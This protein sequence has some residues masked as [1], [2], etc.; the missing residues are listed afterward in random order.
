MVSRLVGRT[1][2]NDL[3]PGA[4]GLQHLEAAA[5]EIE[6]IHDQIYNLLTLF[7]LDTAE[8]ED[9]D[10]IARVIPP[11]GVDPRQGATRAIGVVT[12]FGATGS[13]VPQGTKVAATSVQFRTTATATIGG[14]GFVHVA[15]QAVEPGTSGNVAAGAVTRIVSQVAGV[16]GVVNAAAFSGG[17]D[18]ETDDHFRNRIRE[19]QRSLC[20]ATPNA[21]EALAKTIGVTAHEDGETGDAVKIFKESTPVVRRVVQAKI[22]EDHVFRGISTLYIDDGN[23]FQGVSSAQLV[24]TLGGGSEDVL[25]SI[26]T[27]GERRLQTSH[28]PIELG[29]AITLEI[30][31]GGAGPWVLLTEGADYTI[32]RSN[33][34]VVLAA[35]LPINTSVRA[36]Y[37]YSLDLVHAVQ[38]AVE[39]DRLD[40]ARW[41]GWR[42]A[43]LVVYVRRPVVYPISLVALL[44]VRNGYDSVAAAN[45][46][47]IGVTYYLN[48]LAIGANVIR[49]S[50]ID[51]MMSVAGVYDVVSLSINGST[52]GNIAIPDERVAKASSIMVV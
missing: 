27:G 16:T 10:E 52:A 15:A 34:R 35:G 11:D 13:Y 33:G 8:G 12:L 37:T 2:L 6:D 24:A 21:L 28:W 22:I 20:S 36:R 3:V 29:T 48:S 26:A 43:G 14:A 51:T 42:D 7:D 25:I 17:C 46:A 49:N 5:R 31:F 23:G 19:H 38:R 45:E 40:P 18:R 44:A 32:N 39:G 30:R 41:P 9:L 50:I 4:I 47:T 1:K